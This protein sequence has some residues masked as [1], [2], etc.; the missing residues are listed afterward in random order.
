MSTWCSSHSSASIAKNCIP[1][2]P[3][4]HYSLRDLPTN[5]AKMWCTSLT[6][7]LSTSSRIEKISTQD[8][9]LTYHSHQSWPEL[10]ALL[11]WTRKYLRYEPFDD[12]M[13]EKPKS[14]FTRGRTT[15]D[16][17]PTLLCS[18]PKHIK[19]STFDDSSQWWG[20]VGILKWCPEFNATTKNQAT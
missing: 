4:S 9:H 11:S 2:I 20:K 14:C 7:I 16:F 17:E 12:W 1:R 13:Q 8:K 10:N 6:K 19:W 15:S 18:R 3:Q 5:L